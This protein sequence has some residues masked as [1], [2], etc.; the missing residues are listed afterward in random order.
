MRTTSVLRL[1]GLCC[2]LG[3][4]GLV[5][6]F[7]AQGGCLG[8]DCYSRPLPGTQRGQVP[9]GLA[10]VAFL[11]A[12]VAGVFVGAGRS[13][14]VRK[15]AVAVALCSAGGGIFATA[16]GFTGA[17]TRGETW[18]MPVLV[19]PALVLLSVAGIVVGVVVRQAELAPR[20][21]AVGV[22]VAACLLPLYQQ[23]TAANFIPALL[24][25]VCVALGSHLVVRAGHRARGS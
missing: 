3:G 5:T 9:W 19:F 17:R 4:A 6:L 14:P 2:V 25:L 20:W 23:Q 16:A 15:A 7:V 1:A 24:G 11:V 12:G 22:I 18:L 8:D 13:M 21:I 10:T